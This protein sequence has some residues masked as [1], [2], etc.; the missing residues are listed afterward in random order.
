MWMETPLDS[1]SGS[2]RHTLLSG[3]AIMCSQ[4]VNCPFINVQ[5]L[6]H[7]SRR[8]ANK[9]LVPRLSSPP[10]TRFQTPAPFIDFTLLPSTYAHIQTPCR[11]CLDVPPS[12]SLTLG[13]CNHCAKRPQPDY[14]WTKAKSDR[15]LSCHELQHGYNIRS[16]SMS[17]RG[18][19]CLSP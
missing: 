14:Y 6:A 4:G 13:P 12:A 9:G 18:V 16:I 15:P 17:T 19:M 7:S 11:S 3:V 5:V 8:C 10:F 1:L 2:N